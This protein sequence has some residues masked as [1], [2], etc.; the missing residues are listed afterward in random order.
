MRKKAVCKRIRSA[1][2]ERRCVP[3]QNTSESIQ[4]TGRRTRPLR[5]SGSRRRGASVTHEPRKD[6][7]N[8]STEDLGGDPVCWLHLLCPDCGAMITSEEEP[9]PRC[10][11]EHPTP[12]PS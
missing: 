4:M 12:G 1:C 11:R 5:S 10:G 8:D 7:A 6:P 9:C 3:I 2:T